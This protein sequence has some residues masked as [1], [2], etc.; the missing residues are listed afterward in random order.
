MSLM[1]QPTKS[2]LK[3]TNLTTN[4][5]WFSKFN[6]NN[7][8]NEPTTPPISPRINNLFSSFRKQPSQPQQQQQPTLQ[9]KPSD[10]N[11]LIL[12]ELAPKELKRVRFPITDMTQEYLFMREDIITEKNTKK[13]VVI[14][15]IHIQTSAQLLS[16][17]ELVCRNKQQPTIDLVVSTLI[18]M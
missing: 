15:P 14:E 1:K 17:Y 18:V 8:S 7:N 6:N 2:I 12:S 13:Q 11:L 9:S 4:T 3:Q 16:L 5:S 10:D